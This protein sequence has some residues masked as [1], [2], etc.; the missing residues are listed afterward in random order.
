M[1]YTRLW[2]RSSMSCVRIAQC[3]VRLPNIRPHLMCNSFPIGRLQ[4]YVQSLFFLFFYHG[5]MRISS[6]YATAS[7]PAG[8]ILEI[9]GWNFS[10]VT[11]ILSV[12][13]VNW[14]ARCCSEKM[15]S[16]LDN[17]SLLPS[18]NSNYRESLCFNVTLK[19]QEGPRDSWIH[20]E[21]M[22]EQGYMSKVYRESFESTQNQQG[23][24]S[25]QSL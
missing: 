4:P 11:G 18:P 19:T 9:A 24:G 15:Y 20:G 16:C 1:P 23:R 21:A 22:S 6:S 14:C 13:V 17:A 12:S 5:I 25:C 3:L 7:M 8:A 2:V 10:W